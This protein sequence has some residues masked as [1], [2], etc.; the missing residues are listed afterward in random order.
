MSDTLQLHPENLVHSFAMVPHLQPG[1][2]EA[3]QLL[4]GCHA[5][6]T[7]IYPNQV[8]AI[9]MWAISSVTMQ[10][11][12][13]FFMIVPN[14]AEQKSA[15]LSFEFPQSKWVTQINLGVVTLDLKERETAI[16]MGV[17]IGFKS[18]IML[19]ANV[20]PNISIENM[21]AEIYEV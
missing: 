16:K 19:P 1:Q 21:W 5:P 20:R 3:G 6:P 14:Q 7:V 17:V 13:T 11:G 18:E 15:Q 10:G 2:V 8:V 12:G 9:R 4:Y